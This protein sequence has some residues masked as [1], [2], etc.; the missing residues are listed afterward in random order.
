MTKDEADRIVNDL[1]KTIGEPIRWRL[2][3]KRLRRYRFDV[4]VIAFGYEGSMRLTGTCSP[5]KW[6]YV[7]LGPNNECLRKIST[8]HPGHLHPDGSEA[9]EQHKHYWD[10]ENLD[11]WTYVPDDIRWENHNLALVDFIAECRITLLHAA[12][13]LTIQPE[14]DAG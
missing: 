8:P 9:D 7:L 11:W 6:S 2:H 4:R 13:T 14:R 3:Q 10:E 5:T 12:P 1:D